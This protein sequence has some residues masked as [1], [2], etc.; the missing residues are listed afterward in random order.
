LL[1]LWTWTVLTEFWTQWKT[2]MSLSGMTQSGL[3]FPLPF[4]S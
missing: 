2:I 4:T 1:N 3:S